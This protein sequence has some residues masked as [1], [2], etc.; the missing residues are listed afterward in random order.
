MAINKQDK[1]L[2]IYSVTRSLDVKYIF[3]DDYIENAKITLRGARNHAQLYAAYTSLLDKRTDLKYKLDISDINFAMAKMTLLYTDTNSEEGALGD[4]IEKASFD[5]HVPQTDR[6][7]SCS[8]L[9]AQ[10]FRQQGVAKNK[11]LRCTEFNQALSG[12]INAFGGIS[13]NYSIPSN[14]CIS[15]EALNQKIQLPMFHETFHHSEQAMMHYFSSSEG[16]KFLVHFARQQGAQYVYGLVCD[17]YSSRVLCSNCNVSFLGLQ[18]S[19]DSGFLADFNYSLTR[20][21]I[22]PRAN[23]NTLFSTRASVSHP[24]KNQT[25]AVFNLPNDDKKAHLYNPDR[26]NCIFQAKNSSLGTAKL[27]KENNYSLS[28][29]NGSFFVSKTFSKAKLESAISLTI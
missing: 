15:S 14:T 10:T 19:Y 23:G 27:I 29:F 12:R 6:I 28:D 21:N 11:S 3:K 22:E 25:M 16:L 24:C 20:K 26:Q 9:Y 18:N 7:L 17:V 4:D 5:V 13:N 1:T 2:P 8:D